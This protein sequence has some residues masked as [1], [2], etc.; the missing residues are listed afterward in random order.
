[1]GT[2]L[3]SQIQEQANGLCGRIIQY[4]QLGQCGR[5]P[6]Y[7]NQADKVTTLSIAD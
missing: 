7:R 1:L 2:R 5:A 3:L 4:H 6:G